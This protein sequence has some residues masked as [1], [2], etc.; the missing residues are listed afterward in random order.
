MHEEIWL[1]K[2]F[3]DNLPGVG[4]A[5]L[6]LVGMPAQPRPWANFIVMEFLVALILMLLFAFLR[7][8]LSMDRPGKLQHIFEA[9]YNFI[10]GQSEDSIGHGSAKYVP[11]FGTLFVFILFSNLMGVIPGFE[12][13]TMYPPVT[14]G[15]AI[16]TF[17]YYNLMGLRELGVGTYLAHFAGPIWWLA[18]LMLP[19]ELISH[20]ARPLSLSVRLYANMYAGEQ[21]TLVFLGL[22]YFLAPAIFM[23]LHVFVSLLQAYIFVLLSMMYVSGAVS[24]EH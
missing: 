14:A 22:T 18:W 13:P 3:N 11:Y 16:A 15:C 1:A 20:M 5:F 6:K 21:V 24:H 8:R 9:I 12:S 23:G 2:L 17:C 19:I 4:N 7:P 10:S